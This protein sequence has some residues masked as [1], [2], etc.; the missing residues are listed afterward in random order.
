MTIEWLRRHDPAFEQ[1]LRTY[2]FSTGP[3]TAA[4]AAATDGDQAVPSDGS[5]GIGSLKGT[6]R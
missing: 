5:L 4:E 3:I 1:H 6:G 2:L